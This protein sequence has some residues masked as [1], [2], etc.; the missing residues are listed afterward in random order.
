MI[1]EHSI[2]INA[3]I[4]TVWN[5]FVDLT[6]WQDWNG[7]ITKVTS[8][9]D[10]LTEGKC[11]RFCINPFGLPVYIEPVVNELIPTQKIVWSGRKYGIRARHEFLFSGEDNAVLLSSRE[12]FRV[13]P[14]SNLYLRITM[15]KL[16]QMS[17]EMLHQLKEASEQYG[18]TQLREPG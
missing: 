5:I 12:E 1:I 2:K 15:K 6:C 10:R 18:D 7:V 11:L 17:I 4:D 9:Y 16:H 8:D 14:L 13:N 3:D